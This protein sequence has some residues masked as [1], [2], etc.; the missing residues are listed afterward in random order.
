M[1]T[2]PLSAPNTNW[3]QKKGWSQSECLVCH[4]CDWLK[5]H[6]HR[7][8]CTNRPHS[9]ALH[10]V[11]VQMSKRPSAVSCPYS[12]RESLAPPWDQARRG[13]PTTMRAA[14]SSR[15]RIVSEWRNA[16]GLFKEGWSGGRVKPS[17]VIGPKG[18]GHPLQRRCIAQSLQTIYLG[19]SGFTD[20]KRSCCWI[21]RARLDSKEVGFREPD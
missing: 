4:L 16:R 19:I 12:Q 3:D 10:N 2:I 15:A 21:G 14:R 17:A 9:H 6:T 5:P 20:H 1:G 18:G 8:H 13:R 7:Q 11:R